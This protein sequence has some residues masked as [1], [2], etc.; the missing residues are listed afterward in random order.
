[1]D[2]TTLDLTTGYL[3]LTLRNPLVASPS[4][5]NADLGHLRQLEDNG[6]GAVVLPSLFEEQLSARA[7]WLDDLERNTEAHNP[8]ASGYFPPQVLEGPYG[9][10]PDAYLELIRQA[11]AALDVPVIASLNGATPGGWVDHAAAI[12]AAGAD[13]LE[14]NIYYVP[15]ELEQG[16][17]EIEER[18]LQVLSAVRA[19]VRIPVVVK[20]PPYFSAI[21]DM[22]SRFVDGGADG[23]VVFNRFLQPDID[24]SRMTLSSELA[25]SQPE[26]MRLAL[27]WVAVLHG[28][29]R[30]SLAASTGVETSEQVVKYLLAGADVVMTTS[31]LLRH[32]PGHVATLLAGLR[33]WC[34]ARGVASLAE[35]RGL[36]SRERLRDNV[37]GVYERANY[38]HLIA[39]YSSHQAYR[40]L[41]GKG[42]H[43]R[44]P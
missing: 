42:A 23:L 18:Y 10:G 36:M 7:R 6:I 20:M 35:I 11:R 17:R 22:A 38:L 25:L 8:E 44:V 15:V 33:A 32:G 31:A 9:V 16:G 3:G 41:F 30:C 14:L 29:L 39:H 43:H 28:R 4:P 26:E 27:L 12:E 40:A 2:T 13:A 19:K 34:E 37:A 21:A 5:D 1:M 24:L